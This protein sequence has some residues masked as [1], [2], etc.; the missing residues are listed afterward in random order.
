[1]L[2]SLAFFIT[3]FF[4]FRPLYCNWQ[5]DLDSDCVV[6]DDWDGSG[7]SSAINTAFDIWLVLVPAFVVLRLQM[8]ITRKLSVIPVFATGFP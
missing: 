2:L 7:A 5:V 1:M 3:A 8:K 6:N 4:V